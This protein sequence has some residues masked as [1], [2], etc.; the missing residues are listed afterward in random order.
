MFV[1]RTPKVRSRGK[2]ERPYLHPL[3]CEPPFPGTAG[4]ELLT[5]H[6]PPPPRS[7]IC[8]LLH[9]SVHIGSS[10]H[11]FLSFR[12]CKEETVQAMHSRCE[13]IRPLFPQCPFRSIPE[14]YNNKWHGVSPESTPYR[15]Q[16]AREGPSGSAALYGAALTQPLEVAG[17]S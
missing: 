15:P 8:H 10:S 11:F 7:L 13:F 16:G 9:W 2:C 6:Q 14:H 5:L 4:A 12:L 17:G 3:L 1:I